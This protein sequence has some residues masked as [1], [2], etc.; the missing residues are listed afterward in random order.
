MLISTPFFIIIA[1]RKD[2]IRLLGVAVLVAVLICRRSVCVF[3]QSLKHGVYRI[4]YAPG[5]HPFA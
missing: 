3:L 4:R 5:Y 1:V 2:F